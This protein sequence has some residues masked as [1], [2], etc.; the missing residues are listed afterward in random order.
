M[1]SRASTVYCLSLS[2]R[3]VAQHLAAGFHLGAV[4]EGQPGYDSGGDSNSM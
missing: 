1:A 2:L 4:R 3:G